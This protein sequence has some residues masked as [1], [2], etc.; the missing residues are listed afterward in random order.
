MNGEEWEKNV[1][2]ID[3]FF[4]QIILLYEKKKKSAQTNTPICSD[5]LLKNIRKKL[6]YFFIWKKLFFSLARVRQNRKTFFCTKPNI[7]IW[8]DTMLSV[9]IKKKKKNYWVHFTHN[10]TNL[11]NVRLTFWCAEWKKKLSW[12]SILFGRVFRLQFL[13][14]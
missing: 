13:C 8:F 3:F 7:S 6:N 11:F 14:D 12:F 2:F 5:I 10:Q 4:H 9:M 1:E